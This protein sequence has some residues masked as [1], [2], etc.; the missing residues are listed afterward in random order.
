[1]DVAVADRFVTGDAVCPQSEPR[2]RAEVDLHLSRVVV[3]VASQS[4]VWGV[5]A[6]TVRVGERTSAP[7]PDRAHYPP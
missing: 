3:N 4:W 6:R 5:Q 1:M 2:A 7:G